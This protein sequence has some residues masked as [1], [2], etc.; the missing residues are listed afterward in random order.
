L[1]RRILEP[2]KSAV[3]TFREHGLDVAFATF[4]GDREWRVWRR[5]LEDFAELLF[6]Q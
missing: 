4:P 1:V 2:M 6:N 3:A 5:S